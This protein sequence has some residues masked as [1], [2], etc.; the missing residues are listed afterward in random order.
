[1]KQTKAELLEE[2]ERLQGQVATLRSQ[3]EVSLKMVIDTLDRANEE[4]ARHLR[5]LRIE[6]DG[7]RSEDEAWV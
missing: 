4:V 2:M 3:L 5:T 6:D 7:P 1:M